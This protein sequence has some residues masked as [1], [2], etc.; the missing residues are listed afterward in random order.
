MTCCQIGNFGMSKVNHWTTSSRISFKIDGY[1]IHFAL[2][3]WAIISLILEFFH[4]V[5]L[6]KI[7]TFHSEIV[8]AVPNWSFF[9][10]SSTLMQKNTTNETNIKYKS[11]Y[12]KHNP[13]FS[14]R[15]TTMKSCRKT[16]AEGH[17]QPMSFLKN[18]TSLKHVL[19]I[20][21]PIHLTTHVGCGR[22][23][24][25]MAIIFT[26]ISNLKFQVNTRWYFK[27]SHHNFTPI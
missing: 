8:N 4:F 6:S 24:L 10:P 17:L 2:T 11:S 27:K 7:L 25:W 14:V 5:L 22:F 16:S 18:T 20:I 13:I 12:S 3:L 23:H 15:I 26:I 1:F 9:K 19:P 21:R